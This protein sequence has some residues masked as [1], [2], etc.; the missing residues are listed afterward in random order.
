MINISINPKNLSEKKYILDIIFNEF[1]GI[2]Y[3]LDFENIENTYRI[4]FSTNK[5]LIIY[6]AFWNKLENEKDYLN[7][8]YIP[9]EI[10]YL[11]SKFTFENDL[12]VLYGNPVL[13]EKEDG[14]VCEADIFAGVYF[15]L[16][17]WEE[18]ISDDMDQYGRFKYKNSVAYKFNLVH[19]P[20]VNEYAEFLW[21][22]I[23]YLY[24]SITRVQRKYLPVITHDIDAPL[25]LLDLKMLRN[26]FFRNLIKR[27]NYNNALRDIPVY[28]INK[29][30]PRFDLGNSYDLLMDASESIG[31]KSNFFFIQS[32]KTKFDPGYDNRSKLLQNIFKKIKDRGHNIGIHSSYYSLED[33]EKWK[34][35]YQELCNATGVKIK[36]GRH[37]YLRFKVPF[38]WQV[39]DDNGLESDH[40]LGFAEMEG[41]RCGTCYSYSVYNFLTRK[42]LKLKESPLILMEV[43]VTEYQKLDK[44]EQFAEKL[45][46]VVN[47]VKRYNGEFVFLYHNS[48]FDTKYLTKE[49]YWEWISIIND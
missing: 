45:K 35:E 16:T 30:N 4:R 42:K 28:F 41:F 21:N 6:D 17:R 1:L 38:T 19:R 27:K 33:A 31:V 8:N 14:I 47:I 13:S 32:E 40:T 10:K 5:S 12:P 3:L 26:S 39:W 34:N 7:K 18:Y 15:F 36:N 48:F 49:K 44:P 29:F 37:H 43:S 2:N 24:P 20:V 9:V 23:K 22:I 25:R 11:K 46:N